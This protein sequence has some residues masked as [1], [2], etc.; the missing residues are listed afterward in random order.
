M[1]KKRTI[2][3]GEALSEEDQ[4]KL[5]RVKRQKEGAKLEKQAKKAEGKP[6]AATKAVHVPGQKGGERVVDLTAEM[7]AEAEA[8][9]RKTK[10]AEALAAKETEKETAKA[11][12]VRTRGKIYKAAKSKV[13]PTKQYSLSE[14]LGL[15]RDVSYAKFGGTVELHLTLKDKNQSAAVD[16]PFSSGKI[17]RVAVAD[18]ETLAE[19]EKGQINFDVLL[20]TPAQMAGL[21]KYAK[22]L[23]PRGLMPNPKNGTIVEDPKK[24]VEKLSASSTITLKTDKD[25]VAVHA[26]V[27]KLSQ[28]DEELLANIKVLLGAFGPK[29]LRAT[30]K[31]TMSPGI[32]LEV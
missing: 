1:G 19:I 5:E 31:S 16:L 12:V 28:K 26:V 30:L 2:I 24:A 25:S 6:T 8:V 17:R 32:H 13:E 18:T 10:E 7:L 27:G 3:V 20:A 9:E 11:K 15:L 4:E 14:A 23:G 22:V 21:V 29:L